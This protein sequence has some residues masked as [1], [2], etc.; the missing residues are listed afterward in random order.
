MVRSVL[1][2]HRIN[3][4]DVSRVLAHLKLHK[5]VGPN[6]VLSRPR[7]KKKKG[8][9]R[10]EP[11]PWVR[12]AELA[13][14]WQHGLA[15]GPKNKTVLYAKEADVW[16]LVVPVQEIETH[17][18][19]Q[20]LD[21]KSTMPL[22]RD[23][24]YHHIQKSIVG[25]SRRA[26]YKFLEKQGILQITKNIPDERKKGGVL[27]EARGY[28]EIDLIEGKGRDLYKYFGPRGD[29]YW[30]SLIDVFTGLAEITM[31]RSKAP[32]VVAPALSNLLD[33]LEIKLD[34]KMTVMAMDHGREF[35][36]DVLKMLKK[37]HIR[38]KQVP[39]GSRVEKFNQDFQRNFYRLLRLRRG[40]FSSLEDQALEL[41]NNTR[42]KHTKK[43]PKEAAE[44]PDDELRAPYN[45]SREKQKRYKGA[46]PK[47]GDKCRYLVKMR[48]NM[49][50]MLKLEGQARLYKSY[51]GRHFTK[52]LYKIKQISDVSRYKRPDDEEKR[53][54]LPKRYY[55]NGSWRD[56][57]QILLVSGV[58][59]ETDRQVAARAR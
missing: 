6:D 45:D 31:I 30:L 39:R 32:K 57:D 2:R 9:P 43:T 41:C 50:P 4:S 3:E 46:E 18:R 25:I 54:P 21:P 52:Q 56:R 22:G 48:K 24:A 29:W 12:G 38:H 7:V 51:H 44:T 27:L 17:L 20:M 58:D 55:V 35:Y 19:Q 11:I 34:S 26:L 14:S 53:P 36:T 42:N 5:R 15:P 47:I 10:D 23:S 13:G 8:A 37:R 16:K 1:R 40:T 59:A 33:R 28:C 49:R